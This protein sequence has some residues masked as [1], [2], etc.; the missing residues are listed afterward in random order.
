MNR[1]LKT[2][3]VLLLVI[4]SAPT[5]YAQVYYTILPKHFDVSDGAEWTSQLLTFEEPIKGFRLTVFETNVDN[6]K[7]KGYPLVTFA[8]VEFTDVNGEEIT[9]TATT[10]SLA[11]NDGN[12]IAGLYDNDFGNSG[13]YHSAYSGNVAIDPSDY[14]YIEFLF[15][16]PQSAFTYRQVRRNNNYDIPTSFTFSPL[17]VEANPPFNPTNP[18]EPSV[19]EEEVEEVYYNIK[20]YTKNSSI[21]YVQNSGGKYKQGE[22]V[23]LNTVSRK[24]NYKFSHWTM[25][26]EYYSD[27]YYCY[28]YVGDTDATF[29]AH[30]EFV[31]SS[32][33]EPQ[34]E[35]EIANNPL[36][37][38]TNIEGACSFNK[39]SGTCY[40]VD[41]WV[42]LEAYVSDRYEFNGWYN[43]T[44]LVS[45]STRFNYQMPANEVT[46]TAKVT[47]I[48]FDPENPSEPDGSQTNVQT[49]PIGDI[50]KD[51]VVDVFDVVAII[52]V[53]L[54]NEI[55]D[56]KLHDING[57]GAV[58]VFDV[59]KVINISLE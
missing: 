43:G 10:N 20:V 11:N 4:R 1:F 55:V 16:E 9:Y 18:I 12:G 35:V 38:T 17:G 54:D 58:D 13:H 19:K 8:E 44:T 48:V 7:Y 33:V 21:A 49:T 37:L 6:R 57:D 2:V 34:P 52:N 46:L 39:T 23:T 3:L 32:P 40:D 42:T 51:G 50:N 56:L 36:F 47:K 30:Y 22:R 45:S 53:S 15:D 25:N 24:S 26:G 28:Y 59:V 14:V 41:T 5:I 29:E 27:D 31:P